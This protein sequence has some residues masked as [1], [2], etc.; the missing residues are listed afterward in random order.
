MA[1]LRKT[2]TITG[3]DAAVEP[4]R[5]ATHLSLTNATIGNQTGYLVVDAGSDVGLHCRVEIPKNYVGS[6]VLVVRGILDG[7]P[8][9]SDTLG[10]GCTGIARADNE[11]VD[12]AYGSEDAASATIGSGGTA[13]SDEDQY[14]ETITLTNLGAP[15]V[16]DTLY[17]YVYL[18]ASATSYAGN[19]I[20]TSI[21]L[22][23]SDA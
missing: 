6:P 10:F 1:T 3:L 18:D 8:G 7:A 20:F 14:E 21:Q 12:A 9:A 19:F 11:T 2:C 4:C 13:H 5:I 22:Q 17:L 16:D 23:Y 15:A